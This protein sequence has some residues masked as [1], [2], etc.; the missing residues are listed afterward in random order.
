VIFSITVVGLLQVSAQYGPRL[1]GSFMRATGTKVV[2]GVFLGT[3]VY[4]LA[5]MGRI[6]MAGI[7]DPQPRVAVL[8]GLVLAVTSFASLIFFFHHVTRFIQVPRLLDQVTH[9]MTA[10]LARVFPEGDEVQD[11][12]D[13]EGVLP[14]DFE[15]TATIV[16]AERSGYVQLFD[17]AEAV[18][19]ADQHGLTLRVRVRPGDFVL[20]SEALLDVAPDDALEVGVRQA[21]A[22]AFQIGRERT[23]TQDPEFAVDQVSDMALRALSPGI[24]DPG[25]AVRCIDRLAIGLRHLAVHQAPSPVVRAEDGRVLL[26]A[27]RHDPGSIVKAAFAGIRQHAGDHLAVLF[28]LLETIERLAALELPSRMRYRLIDEANGIVA[29]ADSAVGTSQDRKDLEARCR[30]LSAVLDTQ[31]GGPPSKA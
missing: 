21:L 11:P 29:L 18:S 15:A 1:L 27:R 6:G 25:T 20:E 22:R 14:E 23:R 16:R 17:E 31:L 13:V 26:V 7:D 12:E 24:N 19:V 5:V 2:L 9:D 30:T 10:T 3:F 28:R 8:I 4:L